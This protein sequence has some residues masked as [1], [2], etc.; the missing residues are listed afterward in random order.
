MKLLRRGCI[1][2][3]LA[4]LAG[5][6]H[7]QPDGSL[8]APGA[9]DE[10][11]LL[12]FSADL[13]GNQEV[14]PVTTLGQGKMDAVLDRY[15]RQL[16]WKLQYA[17]LTGP[18]TGAHFH[19]PAEPGTSAPVVLP[20][21]AATSSPAEGAVQ[22]SPTQADELMAGRWYVNLHTQAFPAGEVRGQLTQR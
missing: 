1:V 10:A 7:A 12:T 11:K 22:L 16:R 21:S 3:A 6:I 20:L 15:T 8:S 5:C 14:P 17:H 13:R 2:V 4:G 19:G 18:V 9:Q